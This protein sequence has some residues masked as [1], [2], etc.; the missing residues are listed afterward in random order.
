MAKKL[1]DEDLIVRLR[2]LARA[3]RPLS[4]RLLVH[5]GEVHARGLYREHAY[6][7]MFA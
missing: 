7:S 6:H 3:D 2:A 5:L 4:A 1:A